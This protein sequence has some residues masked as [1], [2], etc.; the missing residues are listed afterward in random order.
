M[1]VVV[2]GECVDDWCRIG[3][4]GIALCHVN[5]SGKWKDVDGRR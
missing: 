5:L 1:R 2:G 4:R 3:N